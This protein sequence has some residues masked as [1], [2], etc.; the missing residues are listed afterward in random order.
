[1]PPSASVLPSFTSVSVFAWFL[2]MAGEPVGVETESS[3]A[4]RVAVGLT[5]RT[6]FEKVRLV[7]GWPEGL[8][9]LHPCLLLDDPA[10]GQVLLCCSRPHGP[11][12]ID[13]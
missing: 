4:L 3:G 7:A 6:R 12:T 1:M 9:V 2:A 11:V 5:Y 13:L 10:P 8:A